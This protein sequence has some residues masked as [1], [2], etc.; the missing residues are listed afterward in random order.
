MDGALKYI[1]DEFDSHV[2]VGHH[3]MHDACGTC[4]FYLGEDMRNST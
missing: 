3:S 4:F 2:F 1:F